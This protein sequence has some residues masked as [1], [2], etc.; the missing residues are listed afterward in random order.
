MSLSRLRL[1]LSVAALAFLLPSGASA[2]SDQGPQARKS[3]TQILEGATLD[4]YAACKKGDL[5]AAGALIA[6]RLRDDKASRWKRVLD[7]SKPKEL[8][9][10]RKTCKRVA[11]YALEKGKYKLGKYQSQ[12]ESEG[13]WHVQTFHIGDKKVIFAWLKLAT[14]YALGDID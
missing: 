2:S 7:T 13:V 9:A 3:M 8:E 6:Y 12:K 1:S 4:L 10:A 11:G 5:K 14:G